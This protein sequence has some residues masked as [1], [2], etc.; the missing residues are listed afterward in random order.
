MLIVPSFLLVRNRLD[1]KALE[2]DSCARSE[3]GIPPVWM[4]HQKLE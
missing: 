2:P 3:D 1:P 4:E